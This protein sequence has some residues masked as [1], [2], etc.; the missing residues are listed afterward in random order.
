MPQAAAALTYLKGLKPVGKAGF[1]FGSYGWAKAAAQEA[2]QYF[3]AMKLQVTREP[4]LSQF[5]PKPEIL[6]ECRAAGRQLAE[7]ALEISGKALAK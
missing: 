5:V 6:D 1:F 3:E 4:L 2:Q 7:K